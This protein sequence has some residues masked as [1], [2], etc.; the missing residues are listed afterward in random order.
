MLKFL[1]KGQKIELLEREA[2]AEEQIAFASICFVF[3]DNWK[4]LD[5]TVQFMQEDSTY[6]V[7]LGRDII[8]HGFVPAE[9]QK[10]LVQISVFGYAIDG[11]VRATTIPIDMRIHKSGFSESGSTPVPPTPDLYAQLLQKLDEKAAS[12]ENGK[13][14]ASAYELAVQSG[15]IGTE[16]QWLASLQGEKG[17]T[18]EQ[19]LPGK[20]GEK[21]DTGAQ[22]PPGEKGEKGDTGAQGIPGEK[23]EK[24]D[25]GADGFSPTVTV[26]QTETGATITVTDKN[27]TT[28]AEIKN[29]KDGTG[30]DSV[31]LTE[32][33]TSISVLQTAVAALQETTHTH[34]NKAYLDDIQVTLS[35][36]LS[37][38]STEYKEADI[39]LSKRITDLE[40]SVGDIQTALEN[41]VG[42]S[43]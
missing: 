5:K 42:V 36:Y 31:D 6:H 2:V 23:G 29:G 21:G 30:S 1:V 18:G 40:T 9:L 24:G 32:V 20:K 26:E 39:G 10:G 13:D 41:I 19:G 28:S 17:D 22:G 43:E 7:H 37:T 34:A 33:E 16:E 3:S 11:A 12:L 25:A 27:G 4:G 35:K 14:G 38:F 15:F 8:A